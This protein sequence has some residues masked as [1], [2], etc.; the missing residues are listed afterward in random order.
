VLIPLVLVL[1]VAAPLRADGEKTAVEK[2]DDD[3]TD[4]KPNAGERFRDLRKLYHEN[5]EKAV[6]GFREFIEEFPDDDL[7]DDARYWLAMSLERARAKPEQIVEA[8]QALVDKHPKSE[9]ADD[10]LYAVAETNARRVRRR[11]DCPAAIEAYETFIKTWPQSE[12]LGE[13]KLKIGELY[14]RM[15]NNEEALRYFRRVVDEHPTSPFT[16]RARMQMAHACFRMDNIDEALTQYRTLLKSPLGDRE[17]I[18]ARLGIV[19]CYLRQKDG[20][21][22]AVVESRDIRDEA[23]RKNALEDYADFATREKLAGYYMS[24]QRFDEA[25]TEYRAYIDRF[26]TSVGVWQAK[27]NIGIIRVEAKKYAGA[28]EMFAEINA[29]FAGQGGETPWYLARSMFYEALS[30][31]LEGKIDEA[32]RLY[33]G[34]IEK[35]PKSYDAGQARKRLEDLDKAAKEKTEEKPRP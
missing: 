3:K 26:K 12:R 6:K 10:A 35:H 17:L 34:L 18:D 14:R 29:K 11:E 4:A 20:L 33:R 31:E 27:L 21:D 8:Y 15:G 22:K 16:T 32:R 2:P 19:D 9:W 24:Q 23:A 13:A 28:R 7:T 5:A 25:E 1:C 30:F